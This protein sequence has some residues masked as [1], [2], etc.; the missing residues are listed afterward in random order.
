MNNSTLTL[1][2]HP[3]PSDDNSLQVFA[4]SGV[5]DV[6]AVPALQ[7]IYDVPQ[8]SQVVL[9]F[10][11]VQ[12]VN[13]MG[14]AQLL[15]LF[16]H[17]QARG[18]GIRV[19]HPNRMV[20]ML[21]KMTG[22][23]HFLEGAAGGGASPAP[24]AAAVPASAPLRPAAGEPGRSGFGMGRSAPGFGDVTPPQAL[25]ASTGGS[26]L[27]MVVSM[28]SS[29]QLNGWYFFN[30]YLQRRLGREVHLELVHGALGDKNAENAS[31]DLVFA[32][33]FDA[34]RL[35]LNQRFR[36]IARPVDHTDEVTILVRAD[37]ERSDLREFSGARVVTASADSFVYLLGRFLMDEGGVDS[38][39]MRYQFAG[40]E[41]KSLQMLIRK[42]A[43]V[44]LMLS[45][46][47]RGLSGLSRRMLRE[48][49]ASDSHFAFHMF[50]LAPSYE[51]LDRPL[52]ELLL[53]IHRDVQG[54]QVLGDL[55]MEGWSEP[56]SEEINMLAM[57]YNRY[58]PAAPVSA[59]AAPAGSS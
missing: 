5:V 39:N 18:V 54:S 45:E 43:D 49:D 28:Q 11:L 19:I 56:S 53:N 15:K 50:C 30:T 38:S 21:F 13:S 42:E 8:N 59:A 9:D 40:H 20:S 2:I 26:K 3:Q 44:L 33:P 7:M 58:V 14:L 6:E 55:G 27:N 48:V 22:L 51:E 41:I 46:S 17:W 29:Q 37:D 25:P 36:P 32:K 12:R 47:Y 16:E 31:A 57:L 24:Q 34:T 52:R 23:N 4:F 1:Q 10:A 35:I